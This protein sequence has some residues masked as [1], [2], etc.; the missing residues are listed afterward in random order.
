MYKISGNLL[1]P[2]IEGAIIKTNAA[3]VIAAMGHLVTF[4][5]AQS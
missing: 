3:I 4:Y 1:C 2:S 5:G